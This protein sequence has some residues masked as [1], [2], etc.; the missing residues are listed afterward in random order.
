MS[1]VD[2]EMIREKSLEILKGIFENTNRWLS[3]AEAKNGSLI[4]VNGLFLFKSIEYIFEILNG[5]LKVNIVVTG[6]MATIFF[7]AIIIALKSFFPDTSIYKDEPDN[8]VSDGS[9]I[10]IFYEDICKYKSS[11][12]YLQD[13]YKYYLET[14]IGINDLKKIE[15]DYAKEILINAR[16]ASY[17][18]RFFKMALKLNFLAIFIFCI[19]LIMA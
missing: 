6:F 2:E 19:F 7:L 17:K 3:F 16:I 13:I 8:S 10:L 9:R 5:K 15:L 11:K 18:Y 4:G 1:A 14:N 12:L